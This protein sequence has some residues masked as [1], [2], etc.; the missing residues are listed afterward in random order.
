MQMRAWGTVVVQKRR[1]L[2]VHMGYIF[3]WG[4]ADIGPPVACAQGIIGPRAVI[5]LGLNLYWPSIGMYI[6]KRWETTLF[7]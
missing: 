3:V 4:V 5:G 1:E 2:V 7:W 6:L